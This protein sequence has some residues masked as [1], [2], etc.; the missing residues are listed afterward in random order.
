[1]QAAPAV[2]Q[3]DLLSYRPPPS[4]IANAEVGAA[5][6]RGTS[7]RQ[8][9]RGLAPDVRIRIRASELRARDKGTVIDSFEKN[10]IAMVRYRSDRN[11]GTYEVRVD[12]VSIIKRANSALKRSGR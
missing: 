12:R 11:G 10:G 8:T 6:R 4:A 9:V 1:M 2:K 7:R 5:S 3:L